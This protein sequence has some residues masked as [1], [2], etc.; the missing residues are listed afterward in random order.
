MTTNT[1]YS[2]V[3]VLGDT[4][5]DNDDGLAK[6]SYVVENNNNGTKSG[7][8]IENFQLEPDT[9]D[10]TIAWAKGDVQE[11]GFK[12]VHF[13]VA[14]I[15]NLIAVGS[16]AVI[17]GEQA[18][19]ATNDMA[20]RRL[21][22]INESSS[23]D[24][25]TLVYSFIFVIVLS[26]VLAS[27]L[28]IGALATMQQ[29]AIF[30]IQCSLYFAVGINAIAFLLYLL[31]SQ[32]PAAM[33]HAFFALIFTFYAKAVWHRIPYAAAILRTAVTAIRSNLGV[34]LMAFSALPINI[35]WFSLWMVAFVGT[36][37][38][39]FMKSQYEEVDTNQNSD[40]N[41]NTNNYNDPYNSSSTSSPPQE[42]IS[43]LGYMVIM[44]FILSLHWTSQVIKNTVHTTVAGVIG[45][46][47]FLPEEAS[48]CCSKG[49]TDSL[50]RSL[51]HSFGSICFGSLIVAIL[52]VIRS[53]LRNAQNNRNG[54]VLR[55]I[56][57][58]LLT[59]IERLVEYFNKWAFI[60]VGLYGYSYMEAGKNVMTLF[61]ARG[62]TTIISDNL[63]V[64]MLSVMCFGVGMI[65]ALVSTL[66][67]LA[68]GIHDSL[69]IP[70]A[71][72]GL[73]AGI[74]FSGIIM[75]VVLS[76]VD[77]IIVLCAESP[78]E[79]QANHPALHNEVNTA[80][81]DAWPTTPLVT[82]TVMEVPHGDSM[83]A[84]AVSSR[85]VV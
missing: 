21:D 5:N 60:Y 73:V 48:S 27:C 62:W 38:S 13:A 17:F 7:A 19:N 59:W 40:Y 85:N 51:T 67:G 1:K 56:A 30:L 65:V 36:L 81:V 24:A 16:T 20:S 57:Y 18:F 34:A 28:S 49:L 31:S 39:D 3:A 78:A 26:F 83:S 43:P 77:S 79:F 54:G 12:D 47:F 53:S 75:N 76:S 82:A 68:T 42:T 14:F 2:Q 8:Q 15:I 74:M 63:V 11:P 70:V 64:R 32:V 9:G 66:A 52:E 69:L 45:T 55:C 33:V 84:E 61:R 72:I 50:S 41:S 46:W 58:C 4:Y 37:Q 25:D 23:P 6:A 29:H 22:E 71:I 80:W 44:L 35:G 10:P